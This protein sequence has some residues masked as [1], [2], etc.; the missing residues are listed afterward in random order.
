MAGQKGP[1]HGLALWATILG[2]PVTIVAAYF[3]Y[4]QVYGTGK[5]NEQQQVGH[6]KSPEEIPQL[7]KP[8][9]YVEWKGDSIRVI[10]SP[11]KGWDVTITNDL[12]KTGKIL[13]TPRVDLIDFG[14]AKDTAK[15]WLYFVIQDGYKTKDGKRTSAGRLLEKADVAPEKSPE[16]MPQLWKPSDYVEWKGD[17]IRVIKSPPK[18]WDVTITDDL[19]KTGKILLSPTVDLI[20]IG[21]EKN[22]AKLWLYFVIQDGYTTKDG[23]RTTPGR[24]LEKAS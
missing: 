10:K 22:T 9:D 12:D 8:S 17:T 7:W 11:P 24:H 2:L 5:G 3:A 20:N 21:F 1:L 18:G 16:E 19:D 23:K 13:L 14:Y 4:L 15:L 6:D